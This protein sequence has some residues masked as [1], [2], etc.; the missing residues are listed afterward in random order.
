M[1]GMN[2]Q[3]NLC[4]GLSSGPAS[5]PGLGF[6]VLFIHVLDHG[7]WL[8][9]ATRSWGA[10]LLLLRSGLI[11]GW[12][13]GSLGVGRSQLSKEPPTDKPLVLANSGSQRV[14]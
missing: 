5:L 9:M 11:A 13:R 1:V 4:G 2:E 7:P 12:S 3:R 14:V 10:Q 8:P 6:E